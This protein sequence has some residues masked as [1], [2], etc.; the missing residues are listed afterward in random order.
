MLQQSCRGLGRT[1]HLLLLPFFFAAWLWR[2][3]A[4]VIPD[5]G[6]RYVGLFIFPQLALSQIGS[7]LLPML[8]VVGGPNLEGCL[9]VFCCCFCLP[10]IFFYGLNPEDEIELVPE[11]GSGRK[12]RR[13]K[14]E[15]ES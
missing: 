11:F 15:E 1:M 5:P 7:L 6:L 8:G 2:W 4:P 12:R 9:A 3:A 10:L 13:P 14:P